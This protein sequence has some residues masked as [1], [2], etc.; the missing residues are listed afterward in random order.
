[1]PIS[2]Q[3]GPAHTRSSLGFGVVFAAGV[4]LLTVLAVLLLQGRS[5]PRLL[6]TPHRLGFSAASLLQRRGL[7]QCS[8][9]ATLAATRDPVVRRQSEREAQDSPCPRGSRMPLAP[10]VLAMLVVITRDMT[11]AAMLLKGL[12]FALPL[13]AVWTLV[14]FEQHPRSSYVRWATALLLATFALPPV[15]NDVGNL[16]FEESYFAGTLAVGAALLLFPTF[17]R[18]RPMLGALLLLLVTAV[19]YLAKSSML[20]CVLAMLLL[21]AWQL[22]RRDPATPNRE[23]HLR[24]VLLLALFLLLPFSWAMRQYRVSG[25]FTTGTSPDWINAYKGNNPT[26]LQ[27]YPP[28]GMA[29]LDPYDHD[30]LPPLTEEWALS[31]ACRTL[32]LQYVRTH[33][34]KTLQGMAWK[35]YVLF[36]SP[37]RTGDHRYARPVEVAFTLGLVL[38]HVLVAAAIVLGLVNLRQRGEERVAATVWLAL[39]ATI[40]TPYLAGFALP[41]HA[42]VMVLPAA[43]Y[44]CRCMRSRPQIA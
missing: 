44:L 18:R 34:A 40:A 5:R 1:M 12:L 13:I 27:H 16:S 41:R 4:L 17:L 19:V 37:Q 26:L 24:P 43:I 23:R 21:G 25:H 28:R 35:A 15:L 14:V 32:T 39:V 33:P 2:Q 30:V 9:A 36:A 29:D 20:P 8:T 31:D 6:Q 3:A 42:T 22:A 38:S 7:T 10:A 11:L